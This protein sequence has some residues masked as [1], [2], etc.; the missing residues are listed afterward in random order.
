MPPQVDFYI[1][2]SSELPDKDLYACRIANLAY[3]RGLTIYIHTRDDA[4]S[5][6]LDKTLWTFSQS[7][8]IPHVIHRG[9]PMNL[10]KYPVQIGDQ[11]PP[12]NDE[13]SDISVLISLRNDAPIAHN[14][15]ARIVEIIIN[16]AEDKQQGR[17][18]F[19]FYRDN[20]IQPNTHNV[21]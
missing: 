3:A 8:F 10:Q 21:K 11:S 16:D 2:S 13:N 15:F 1:L 9:E 20:G 17:A 14:Q 7:S 12:I 18:R 6:S 19:R 4:H 5:Q